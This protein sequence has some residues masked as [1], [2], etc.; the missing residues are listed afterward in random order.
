MLV[1]TDEQRLM[2]IAALAAHDREKEAEELEARK[3]REF[4]QVYPKGWRR[5]Q[6]LIQK[7][8]PAAR[9]YA[10]LAENIEGSIGAVVVAQEV[11]AN[12]LGVHIRTIQRQTKWLEEAGA[13]VRIKVGVGVYAYALDPTEI[14]RSWDNR[15]DEAAFITKTLVRKSDSA[16]KEVRRKLKVMIGEPELPLD[17][18][19]S[20][21]EHL[22]NFPG[23]EQE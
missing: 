3:N 21:G 4:V 9:I 5:L 18:P 10:F 14:W 2:R 12:A 16:N 11:M 23:M 17:N 7:N 20:F 19:P 22:L 13:L 15:K 6:D 1:A 8:P